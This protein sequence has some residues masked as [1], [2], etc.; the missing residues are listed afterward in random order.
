MTCSRRMG[1]WFRNVTRTDGSVADLVCSGDQLVDS[2]PPGIDPTD[3]TGWVAFPRLV[4]SHVHLDKTLLGEDWHP[5][6]RVAFIG[7]RVRAERRLLDDPR[8][9]PIAVRARRLLDLLLAMG[10]TRIQSHVDVSAETG[11]NGVEALLEVR[12]E[13]A[14]RV[15]L[16]FVAFPQAGILSSPGTAQLMEQAVGLGVEAVGGI[17]PEIV[18]QDREAHLDAVFGIA[19]HAG[20]RVDIHLHEPG[21]IGV[22]SMR[23]IAERTK[24]LGMGGRVA[25]SHAYAFS[26]LNDNEAAPVATEL[27]E[28]DITLVSAVPGRGMIMPFDLLRSCGMRIVFG[29]D[30]IRDAWSPFG[31]GDALE[32]VALA[33]YQADWYEDSQIVEA[34]DAVTMSAAVMLGD[35]EAQLQTG[36]TADFTLIEASSCTAAVTTR[37]T[38]TNRRASRQSRRRR[39]RSGRVGDLA[40]NEGASTLLRE[41]RTPGGDLVDLLLSGGVI[42]AV[43]PAGEANPA[44]PTSLI[45]G[46]GRLVTPALADPHLHPDKAYLLDSV[47]GAD[48]LTEA[49]A[50]VRSMKPATTEEEIAE[51]ATSLLE[52]CREYGTLAVRAHAEVDEALSLRSIDALLG[53]RDSLAAEMTIQVC[54]F[55][56][57]GLDAPGTVDLMEAALKR[58]AN[59]V[60]GITYVDADLRHHLDT[61][62]RLAAEHGVPLDLHADL[63][64]DPEETALREIVAAVERWGLEGRTALGHCTTL[65]Q[66]DS[67]TRDDLGRLLAD[68]GVAVIALPRT[69]LYLDGV[70]AP[71]EELGD[72]GLA[73]YIATNNVEN[74]FTPAG[75]PSLPEVAVVHALVRRIASTEQLTKLA[76]RLWK[77]RAVVD[78]EVPE[79]AAGSTADLCLWPVEH[80]WQIVTRSARPDMVLRSGVP[81]DV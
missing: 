43:N 27:A 53:V 13:N 80:P 15:D 46:A 74:P 30:N 29:S 58:G 3:S 67:S 66:V 45:D 31:T 41:V 56:Q 64:I 37:P 48:S 20:A 76:E 26:Q 55:A 21:Q 49:M 60:G 65:A 1:L 62:G 78:G 34:L 12:S 22:D 7:E 10:S 11:M 6:E 28:A 38:P 42:S 40:V 18:D 75:P 79:I 39:S 68:A 63:S 50:A 8:V 52:R 24:A 77:A 72:Q 70:I 25:I 59:V 23:A 54:A 32:R 71:I 73:G 19:D 44:A 4:E 17:D 69:D 14:H 2:P 81:I 9:S 33:S 36:D 47:A 5:H 51:R 16:T 35:E 57:E 61:V